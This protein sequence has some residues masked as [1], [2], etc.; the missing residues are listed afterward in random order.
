[1]RAIATT[2]QRGVPPVALLSRVVNL[3]VDGYRN[4]GQAT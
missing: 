1:M 4:A 2:G 3:V